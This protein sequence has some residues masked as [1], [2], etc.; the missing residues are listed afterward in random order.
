MPDQQ[1]PSLLLV[2]KSVDYIYFV[3][4]ENL[5]ALQAADMLVHFE[6][7]LLTEEFAL[8]RGRH[9]SVAVSEPELV[10]DR[11][12]MYQLRIRAQSVEPVQKKALV[13]SV[14]TATQLYVPDGDTP[15]AFVARKKGAL[16]SPALNL[17]SLLRANILSVDRLYP[18][19]D[20]LHG[21][22]MARSEAAD[23]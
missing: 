7:D 21:V 18:D 20:D 6:P 11:D 10:A 17:L 16:L 19:V 14:Q 13:M 22:F 9:I 2:S 3:E 15:E 23:Q 8:D 4:Q 1:E 5:L 12:R